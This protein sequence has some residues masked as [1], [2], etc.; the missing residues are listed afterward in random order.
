[1]RS[2]SLPTLRT[3]MLFL[4][5]GIETAICLALLN[6]QNAQADLKTMPIAISN[7]LCGRSM[8]K[9]INT[10]GQD[11]AY[12]ARLTLANNKLFFVIVQW[13]YEFTHRC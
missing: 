6:L 7:S 1:M 4:L 5:I 13:V 10:N 9:D 12:P 8:V 2:Y 11:G 3:N